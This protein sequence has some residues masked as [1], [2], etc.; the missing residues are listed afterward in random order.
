MSHKVF[1][2][3][4]V[5]ALLEDDAAAVTEL[6]VLRDRRDRRLGRVL[7][8]ARGRVAA[9]HEVDRR[10]LDRLAEG[11][12]HQGVVALASG[13]RAYGEAQIG[14][15]LAAAGGRPLVLV[16]DGVQD[17]HNL[18]ACLRTADAAG[19]GL[20]VAPRDRA[21]GLTPV[22]RK[23]ASGAADS[24]PFIPVVNL[25]RTL[26]ELAAH[27]LWR[28]GLDGNAPTRLAACDLRGPLA[29]VMGG[30]GRGMRRLTREHCDELAA[31]PM[32]GTVASLNVSVAAGVALF[33]AVR[34]REGEG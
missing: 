28:V 17:P 14:A 32:A 13:G 5:T 23:V 9:V 4:A 12:R 31:I 26:D 11:G 2:L 3:H 29:L 6:W 21:A 20:V 15:L 25:A 34:Q 22:A 1:G 18:G 16:L 8:L 27:G 30:E 10:E 24:V 33:E 19:A 7:A